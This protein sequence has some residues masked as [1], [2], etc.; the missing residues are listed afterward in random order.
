M[1][2]AVEEVPDPWL[3]R[4]R[5]KTDLQNTVWTQ[6]KINRMKNS[7]VSH[8]SCRW[9]PS[10][11]CSNHHWVT[12]VP[13]HSSLWCAHS[14][15]CPASCPAGRAPTGG[16]P[17]I[18]DKNS[19]EWNKL[20]QNE[21]FHTGTLVVLSFYLIF[22]TF[23]FIL[24]SIYLLLLSF[25]I[26]FMTFCLN[27]LSILYFSLILLLFLFLNQWK[28]ASMGCDR[29]SFS[30]SLSHWKCNCQPYHLFIHLQPSHYL[31]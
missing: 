24:L 2:G 8:V 21:Q 27:I 13:L 26:I 15:R 28:Q 18:G 25:N 12:Q 4:D 5:T 3:W 20:F 11:W 22:M 10:S 1:L 31:F 23:D 19:P 29:N 14:P 6:H 16:D 30:L 17:E 9:S 7:S